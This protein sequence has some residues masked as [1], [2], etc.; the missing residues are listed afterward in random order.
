MKQNEIKKLEELQ[1]KA[2]NCEHLTSEEIHLR[3]DLLFKRN[4]QNINMILK[5]TDKYYNAYQCW[6]FTKHIKAAGFNQY[7]AEDIE[8]ISINN[9]SYYG[10]SIKARLKSGGETNIKTF[11]DKSMMLGFIIGYNEAVQQLNN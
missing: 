7:K 5:G 9:N 2:N 4:K 3:S 10:A 6:D 11:N 8:S 1:R